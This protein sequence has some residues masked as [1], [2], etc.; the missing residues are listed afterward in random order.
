[1]LRELFNINNFTNEIVECWANC[2]KSESYLTSAGISSSSG[3]FEFGVLVVLTEDMRENW[4]DLNHRE[5]EK[6][7]EFNAQ[8]ESTEKAVKRISLDSKHVSELNSLLLSNCW[9]SGTVPAIVASV[10]C[11]RQKYQ[12]RFPDYDIVEF[13]SWMKV[14]GP[15]AERPCSA[16]YKGQPT[17]MQPTNGS[18]RNERG[19]KRGSRTARR[20]Q[21]C[22]SVKRWRCVPMRRR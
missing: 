4:N 1:M 2:V 6:E 12:E 11:L 15:T 7:W 14:C 8:L 16:F 22:G 17:K 9:A 10:R 3:H 19:Q 20:R 5:K 18:P 13:D 21:R